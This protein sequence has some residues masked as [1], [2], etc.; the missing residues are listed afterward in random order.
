MKLH[1]LLFNLGARYRVEGRTPG[2]YRIATEMRSEGWDI[3]VIDFF[4][5]WTLDELKTL[6]QSR[7]NSDTKFIG[8]SQIFTEWPDHAEQ[9]CEWLKATYPNLVII[10][11]S[12]VYQD[13][14]SKYIDYYVKGYAENSVKA[15]LKYLFSNGPRPVILINDGNRVI[16]SEL[17]YMAAPYK[18]PAIIYEDRDYIQPT[19]WLGIEFSRGCKFAC[20][21]CDFPIL[22]VKGDYTRDVSST[23]NQLRDAYERF[24]T[25]RYVVTDETF[26]DS[27]KK[28]TKFAN[29]VQSLPFTP[30]FTGFI[31][32]D[33]LVSR[34]ADREELLRMNFLGHF[35]G[36]ESFYPKTAK[37]IGKGMDPVRL[38]QGLID[39]KK[40]FKSNGT[41]HYRSTL[42]LIAGLPYE[43]VDSLQETEKW[44]VDNWTGEHVL[45]FPLEIHEETEI[46]NNSHLALNYGDY[47]YRKMTTSVELYEK[48]EWYSSYRV[49][50]ESRQS[51]ILWE[52]D[53]LNFFDVLKR[54]IDFR[55]ENMQKFSM[56]SFGLGRFMYEPDLNAVFAQGNNKN[57]ISEQVNIF[58]QKY[59]NYKLSI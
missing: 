40:Y 12:S 20:K 31:R 16:N 45:Y 11:G 15:L 8:F 27:T 1:A 7:I 22:G 34:Q 43:T 56:S 37:V 3:E 53:N 29:V 23:E 30:L 26:N 35:Y 57:Y 47:N 14:K 41:G 55:K 54:T 52:N 10:F 51:Y 2:C 24:G 19:E 39:V 4:Y 36:V 42:S 18:D 50:V 33:L 28:I 21:F 38:K 44:I 49:G 59:K 25:T 5:F 58:I 32:P 17:S 6:A 9:F 13:L 48:E 46:N